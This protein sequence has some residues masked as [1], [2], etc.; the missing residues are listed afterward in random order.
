[1]SS[2]VEHATAHSTALS[3]T[4][5]SCNVGLALFPVLYSQYLLNLALNTLSPKL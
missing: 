4:L 2:F 1:M 5:H 3:Y